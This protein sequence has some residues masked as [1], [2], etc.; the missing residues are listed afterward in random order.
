MGYDKDRSGEFKLTQG[1]HYYLRDRG[2]GPEND[3]YSENNS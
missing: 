2:S 3:L 1:S